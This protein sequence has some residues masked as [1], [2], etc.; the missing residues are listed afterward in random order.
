MQE[1][2]NKEYKM[3][4]INLH[5]IVCTQ[6]GFEIMMPSGK[7]IIFLGDVPLA[8]ENY[9]IVRDADYVLHEAFSTSEKNKY[10]HLVSKFHS[11]VADVCQKMNSLNVKNLILWHTLDENIEGRKERFLKEGKEYFKGNLFVPNDLEEIIL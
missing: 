1:F 10:T 4:I 3:K 6:F 9:T 5:S 7:N 11:T 8:S 2:K